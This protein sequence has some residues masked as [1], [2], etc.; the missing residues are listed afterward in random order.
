M[1]VV[2]VG[3]CWWVVVGGGWWVLRAHENPTDGNSTKQKL[4]RWQDDMITFCR[5]RHPTVHEPA[6]IYILVEHS[7]RHWLMAQWILAWVLSATV[8]SYLVCSGLVLSD[9]V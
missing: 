7:T 8:W 6:H 5:F 2:G 9:V 3:E 1:V 4:T